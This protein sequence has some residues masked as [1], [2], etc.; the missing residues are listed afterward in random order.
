MAT[1]LQELLSLV[2]AGMMMTTGAL[3]TVAPHN[4]PEGLL[5][6]ANRDWR[7]SKT[8]EPELRLTNVPG[9]VRN[10]RPDASVALEEMFNACLEGEAITLKAVSGYRSY[11]KQS[12]LYSN[13]LERVG[14][15]KA[16]A[17][18]YVARPGASEHQLGLAMDVGQ[19]G[20]VNLTAGFGNTA[21][22][23]WLRVNCW[24]YGF[25][26]RY[27]EAWED[28]TGYKYEP[29]HVRYVGRE[30]A[31]QIYEDPDNPV[32]LEVFL[33]N[34]R[35]ERMANLL[36][37]EDVPAVDTEDFLVVDE[38]AEAGDE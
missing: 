14:G 4:D 9:Q 17:D 33:I 37:V 38:D 36:G 25:I 1:L 6:L 31:A 22:G 28:I 24:E 2:T 21:G 23:K 11:T 32:P 27:Q 12:T 7:V 10:M 29:W 19:S 20:K 16:R 35:S 13:K 26:L 34:L 8:Y 30:Y 3:D 18:E 15:S 5:F